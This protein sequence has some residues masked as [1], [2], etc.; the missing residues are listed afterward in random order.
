M[1]ELVDGKFD[2]LFAFCNSEAVM[3]TVMFPADS[4]LRNIYGENGESYE[5]VSQ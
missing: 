3:G 1:L 2:G 5:P 4:A